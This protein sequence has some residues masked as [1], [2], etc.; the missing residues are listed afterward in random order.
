MGYYKSSLQFHYDMMNIMLGYDK[1][2][3]LHVN[4][5]LLPVIQ[6]LSQLSKLYGRVK[7]AVFVSVYLLDQYFL[8]SNTF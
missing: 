2:C 7:E 1:K 4:V 3:Q 8:T 5:H 6:T